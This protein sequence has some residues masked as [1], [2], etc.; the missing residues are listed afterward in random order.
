LI[1]DYFVRNIEVDLATTYYNSI[2]F[3]KKGAKI[4][5]M[6]EDWDPKGPKSTK[7]PQMPEIQIP[8]MVRQCSD[9]YSFQLVQ[10]RSE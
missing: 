9:L 4:M 2:F 5:V 6:E 7:D 10:D 8:P 3:Y 1:S